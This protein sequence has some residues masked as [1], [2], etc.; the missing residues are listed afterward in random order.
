MVAFERGARH[1]GLD[2][3]AASAVARLPG[4]LVIARPRQRVV[5]PLAGDGIAAVEHLSIDDDARAHA[6]A[7]DHAEH[8]GVARAGA[9]DRLG[10]RKA[11]RI[12]AHPDRAAEQRFEIV[13]ERP[14]VEAHGV[15]SA[16]QSRR[17]RQR[18]RRA[19]PHGSRTR[20]N[21][22]S[23]LDVR[24]EAGDRAQR[25]LVIAMRRGNAVTQPFL[26]F[27]IE[28]DDFDL[29]AAEIDPKPKVLR[30]GSFPGWRGRVALKLTLLPR[31]PNITNS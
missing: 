4:T 1:P 24:H 27:G 12:V 31:C 26:P 8:H 17:A 19:D 5:A 16:Q 6:R 18:A 20:D 13:L 15:R 10:Q 9:V 23:S 11:I 28:C 30:H 25:A 14:A 2:A 21:A 3:S 7:Q 29:G 22:Q